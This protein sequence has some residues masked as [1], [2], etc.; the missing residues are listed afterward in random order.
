MHTNIGQDVIV[1]GGGLAG[2]FT[3]HA[4]ASRGASVSV[5]EARH[6]LASKAS[7]NRF[8]LLT[9]YI[10]TKA[11]SLESLYSTGF[12]FSS[13][14][15]ARSERLAPLLRRCGAL[16]LPSTA[17]LKA[18]LNSSSALYG[19]HTIQR[20]SPH[21]ASALSGI[22]IASAA[23]YVA[24]AGFLE[25]VLAV[26]QL[27]QE[28]RSKITTHYHSK[29]V[30][31]SRNGSQWSIR[32]EDGSTHTASTVVI[33]NAYEASGVAISTWLP[34][35]PVRGQTV[36]ALPSKQSSGLRT[37]LAFGGYLTPV[38]EGSHFV[39]AHYRHDDP[40][41]DP[42]EA[43]TGDILGRC[44]TWLPDAQLEST[45]TIGA[46]VCFRTS[47]I[48]RL[49]YIGALP[50]FFEMKRQAATL[51]SGS[52]L[53]A[54]VPMIH[55]GGVYV[56]VGHGSRGLLSCPLGAEIIARLA[57]NEDLAELSDVAS[58]VTPNRLPYRLLAQS[59]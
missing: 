18:A 41:P 29:V 10:T 25:P 21:D 35:E 19:P 30:T 58:T 44:A 12:A 37:V 42:S 23:F 24:D 15:I 17:R 8:A 39:G 50:D 57:N 3:A 36:S 2:G 45:T 51:R 1:I 14:Q 32:C 5:L 40:N 34:L 22:Q 6:T 48:D 47:T 38:V 16:Q 55:H 46:R 9:P 53:Q 7:G 13:S 31:I 56:H 4:F 52:D 28:H 27:I 33:C 26:E 54:R 43:D 11:S 20:V 49:P 59:C